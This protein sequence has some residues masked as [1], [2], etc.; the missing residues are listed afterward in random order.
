M[1]GSP[2]TQPS[3]LL[4]LRDTRDEQ[5]WR[6]FVEIYAPLIDHFGRKQGLQA[7]DSADLAQEVLQAVA[8]AM[9]RFD[10]DPKQGSFRGW[11]FT[12]TRNELRDFLTS[13]G[14]RP[15]ASG[16]TGVKE[17]LGQQPDAEPDEAQWER[18][19]QWRLFS[20][21]ADRVRGD[22]QESTWQAFWQTAVDHRPAKSVADELKMTVGAVYIAKSR[23]LARLKQMI[24]QVTGE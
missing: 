18:D 5:A 17:L 10:Y 14:R 2:V 22:F 13:R 4:R 20:W 3:L 16:D 24:Q 23:V 9:D 6:Q 19:Y 11:L 7:A 21:G 15:M 12:I 8:G 1:S